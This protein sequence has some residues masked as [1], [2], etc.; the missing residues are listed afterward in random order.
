[1]ARRNPTLD[2]NNWLECSSGLGLAITDAVWGAIWW[3]RGSTS[4]RQF[5]AIRTASNGG[6]RLNTTNGPVA[7]QCYNDGGTVRTATTANTQPI[8]TTVYSLVIW[9]APSN[10]TRSIQLDGGAIVT[11]NTSLTITGTGAPAR[12]TIS[13]DGGTLEMLGTYGPT[14]IWRGTPT[15]DDRA[16]LLAGIDFARIQPHNLL[17]YWRLEGGASPEPGLRGN[18]LTVNGALTVVENPRLFRPRPSSVIWL[19]SSVVATTLTVDLYDGA[20]LIRSAAITPDAAWGTTDIV[21]TDTERDALITGTLQITLTKAGGPVDVATVSVTHPVMTD[22]A[23]AASVTAT[24][25]PTAALTTALPLAG[26]LTAAGTATGALQTAIRLAAGVQATA[27]VSASLGAGAA[28]LEASVAALAAVTGALTTGLRLA[29]ARQASATVTGSLT[30]ALPLAAAVPARATVTAG[31]TT[32]LRLDASVTATATVASSLT[33]ALRLAASVPA[34]ATITGALETALP[35]A[36][37][38]QATATA[39][40]GLT[41]ITIPIY[42]RVCV[43]AVQT[44]CAGPGAVA[45]SGAGVSA[46][47]TS[48][49]GVGHVTSAYQEEC[50][51]PVP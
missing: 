27:T 26:S 34:S 38:V 45:T 18:A 36:A 12:V 41:T 20:T 8:T 24:A 3:M 4:T 44:S 21:L 37:D 17:E 2:G 43:G 5:F 1:M 16:A 10:L 25:T 22:T 30:T 46:A 6:W 23:L 40:A 32:A 39:T 31:L 48:G 19:P 42:D 11:D 28:R 33:T 9:S 7:L 47:R 15:T 14:A 50:V 13:H 51:C 49:T 29:A 35:L